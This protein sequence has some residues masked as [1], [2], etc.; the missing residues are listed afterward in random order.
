MS[1]TAYIPPYDEGSLGCTYSGTL[2]QGQIITIGATM[3]YVTL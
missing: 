3:L 1:A 2:T